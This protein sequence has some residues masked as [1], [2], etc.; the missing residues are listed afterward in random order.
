MQ[1]RL[2]GPPLCDPTGFAWLFPQQVAQVQFPVGFA[3]GLA[4]C[5]CARV[6]LGSSRT[7]PL[8]LLTPAH[9][10]LPGWLLSTVAWS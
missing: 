1:G 6:L 9:T 2:M 5:L 10:E 3:C 4:G 8:T 7:S